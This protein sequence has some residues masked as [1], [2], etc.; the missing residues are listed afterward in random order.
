MKNNKG[1][2]MISLALTILILVILATMTM[3]YG[4]S[5]VKEAKLQD[6][7]TNMLLIQASLKNDLEKYHFETNSLDEATKNSKKSEY[8]KGT[9]LSDSS[10]TEVKEA[11]DKIENSSQVKKKINKD[12]PQVSNFKIVNDDIEYNSDED[13]FQYYYLDNNTL[14][15]LGLKD[16]KSD[17]ENGYY[18]VAYSMNSTF[19]NVVEVINTKG[20]LGNY[21]LMRIE[22]I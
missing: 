3:Y 18:I 12:Y 13:K 1:V 19:P 15:Q 21:S 4:E 9:I 2:T 10:I 11:F 5:A 14:S 16:V 8:L 22:G 20:Y 17:S 6:L 7:K